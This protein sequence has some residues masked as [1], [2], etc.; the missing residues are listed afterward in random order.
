MTRTRLHVTP[1]AE[2]WRVLTDDGRRVSE[3]FLDRSEA[4][5][6]AESLAQVDG[7]ATVYVHGQG[8][9]DAYR[10]DFGVARPSGP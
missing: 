8:D 5:R 10:K 4:V 1:F 7:E 3:L 9:L 2:G 6:R